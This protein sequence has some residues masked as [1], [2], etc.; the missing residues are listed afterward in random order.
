[1]LKYYVDYSLNIL[2]F[3]P[4]TFL[5]QHQKGFLWI[6]SF[7]DLSYNFF[8]STEIKIHLVIEYH[9]LTMKNS[10]VNRL[11]NGIN[12]HIKKSSFK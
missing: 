5:F 7:L 8:L 3:F 9:H 11:L 10:I 1:M 2:D 12:N 4:A 6:I